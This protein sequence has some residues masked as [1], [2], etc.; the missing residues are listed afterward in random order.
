MCWSQ[1]QSTDLYQEV[2]LMLFKATVT[3]DGK[4]RTVASAHSQKPLSVSF[5]MWKL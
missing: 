1:R 2:I 3:K 5:E 4:S